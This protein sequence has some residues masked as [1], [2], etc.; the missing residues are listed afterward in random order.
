MYVYKSIFVI[1]IKSWLFLFLPWYSVSNPLEKY[2]D[3]L[4]NFNIITSEGQTSNTGRKKRNVPVPPATEQLEL[5]QDVVETNVLDESSAQLLI[6]Q[7][8]AIN[9]EDLTIAERG[10]FQE[11]ALFSMILQNILR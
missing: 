7:L 8:T 11:N 5:V 4:V 2:L 9:L 1:Y 10:K 6:D 3:A